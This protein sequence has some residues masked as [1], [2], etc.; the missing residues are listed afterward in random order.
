MHRIKSEMTEED[1]IELVKI[2]EKYI[3]LNEEEK[4]MVAGGV[5][6]LALKEK[7]I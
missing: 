7:G 5:K 4:H 3:A 2:Y 1:K 6:V